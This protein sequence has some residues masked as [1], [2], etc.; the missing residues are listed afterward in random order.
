MFRRLNV[1]RIFSSSS[2]EDYRHLNAFAACLPLSGGPD[3]VTLAD[4]TN[5]LPET[6]HYFQ[7]LH[8]WSLEEVCDFFVRFVEKNLVPG[9]QGEEGS[10]SSDEYGLN[11]YIALRRKVDGLDFLLKEVLQE[12]PWLSTAECDDIFREILHERKQTILD[13]V[14]KHQYRV[15]FVD[16]T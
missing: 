4:V 8:N 11:Y 14:Q 15:R 3:K 5:S 12:G 16:L 2:L 7:E 13:F 6:I 1:W 10:T 9:S